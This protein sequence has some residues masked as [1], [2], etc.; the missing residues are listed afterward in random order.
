MRPRVGVE[1][2]AQQQLAW[3]W[4]VEPF[5][6]HLRRHVLNHSYDRIYLSAWTDGGEYYIKL[7]YHLWLRSPKP[8]ST[9]IGSPSAAASGATV[10]SE[11]SHGEQTMAS[12][13]GDDAR[14]CATRCAWPD[15]G[16]GANKFRR[17]TL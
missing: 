3:P 11:R 6:A 13:G 4:A 12:T 1:G 16:R 15:M 14:L 10:W 7:L 8:R 5:S 9:W 2:G 17:A